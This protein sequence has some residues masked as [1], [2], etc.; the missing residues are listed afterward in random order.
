M[1][2]SREALIVDV[3]F[4]A[5]R[6]KKFIEEAWRCVDHEIDAKEDAK[7]GNS[8][9]VRALEKFVEVPNVSRQYEPNWYEKGDADAAVG[10]LVSAIEELKTEWAS[11]GIKTDDVRVSVIGG[12]DNPKLDENGIRCSPLIRI[13]VGAFGCDGTG[14]TSLLYGHSDKQPDLRELWSEGLDPRRPVI[15]G[16]KIFGRGASDDGYSI[17]CAF[18]A[19]M[20]LREQGTPHAR[21]TILIEGSEESGSPD[22][23]Q[24][25]RD[26]KPELGDV[27]LIV[28]LDSCC[29]N[30]DQLWVTNSLRGLASGALTVRVLDVGVHSG[31]AGSGVVPSS[32]RILRKLI[33]RVEDEDT[34]EIKPDE[35]KVEI[36]ADI[37]EN[38]RRVAAMFKE[39]V[40]NNCPFA[41][42]NGRRVKPVSNDIA[43]LIL[44]RTWRTRLSV[45]GMDGFPSVK[46]A[47]N[48]TLPYVSANLS[49]R[50]P[51]PMKGSYAAD[52]IKKTLE[53]DPPYDA[54]VTFE[55][56]N[57]GDGWL[58]PAASD[59]L[60]AALEESSMAF[61]GK[62]VMYRAEGGSIP[63]MSMLSAMFGES[64]FLV[65]GVG[66]HDTNAHGPDESVNIPMTRRVAMCIAQVL[67]A[68]CAARK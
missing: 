68:H 25:I 2:N 51:P 38:A 65:T 35:L 58:M 18:S 66:G 24:Y 4:D 44:N 22:L 29:D 61:F 42:V 17:F 37:V 62:G 67:S 5:A 54:D 56:K 13:D 20:A 43:E 46:D 32:F 64:Q 27:S 40:Y 39:Y 31:S 59:W 6:V 57:C 34:G 23:E 30:Y 19:L 41:S 50:L 47:G 1:I 21:A 36:P 28:C 55:V 53:E 12:K 60:S 45:T 52:F 8:S 14:A 63:F 3:K 48:V 33:S 9:I 15:R 49:F 11:K 16:E 26:L 7:R 10:V